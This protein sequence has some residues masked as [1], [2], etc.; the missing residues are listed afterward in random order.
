MFT[1]PMGDSPIN[2]IMDNECLPTLKKNNFV[3]E[4][5]IEAMAFFDKPIE[6]GQATSHAPTSLTLKKRTSQRTA[7]QGSAFDYQRCDSAEQEIDL[8]AYGRGSK[9]NFYP[10][11]ILENSKM[12][13]EVIEQCDES[14]SDEGDEAQAHLIEGDRFISFRDSAVGTQ[15]ETNEQA[16]IL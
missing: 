5:G 1:K 8:R 6:L 2:C 13:H 11:G 9:T 10:S 4:V 14:A 3:A 7:G 15:E 16:Q 12:A